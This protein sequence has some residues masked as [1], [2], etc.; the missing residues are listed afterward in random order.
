M[1]GPPPVSLGI[2]DYILSYAATTGSAR[3]FTAPNPR[4]GERRDVDQR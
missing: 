2:S 3:K 1:V 4:G